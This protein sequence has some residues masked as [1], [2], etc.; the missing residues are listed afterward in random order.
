M[1][2]GSCLAPG[3]PPV[4][5]LPILAFVGFRLWQRS[6]RQLLLSVLASSFVVVP[7]FSAAM[8]TLGY[9]TGTPAIE[10]RRGIECRSCVRFGPAP[11]VVPRPGLDLGQTL[12][13]D[14][15]NNVVLRALHAVCGPPSRSYRGPMPSR[16]D[17]RRTR[18]EGRSQTW[19]EVVGSLVCAGARTLSRY[20]PSQA[21][22]S[23]FRMEV[24]G[25]LVVIC[26]EPPSA[27]VSAFF[28]SADEGPYLVLD[29]DTARVLETYRWP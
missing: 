17:I 12:L 21:D 26:R 8:A 20:V 23:R 24:L 28:E 6:R 14:V 19:A 5:S 22:D 10:N 4:L 1:L 18:R 16:S 25:R 11:R 13:T 29:L 27:G 15:P 2:W 3:C 7:V 9:W